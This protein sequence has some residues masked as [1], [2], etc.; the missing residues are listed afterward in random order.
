V[1]A[2]PAGTLPA[3]A[4]GTKLHYPRLGETKRRATM[5]KKKAAKKATAGGK[6]ADVLPG[7]PGKF[8]VIGMSGKQNEAIAAAMRK[9]L[10]GG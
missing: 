10:G 2:I 6:A 5:A 7:V 4:T 3:A 1:T 8:V 9:M